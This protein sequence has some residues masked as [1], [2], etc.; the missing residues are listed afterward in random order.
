[1]SR[2]FMDKLTQ[3]EKL[4]FI[5]KLK[6]LCFERYYYKI[7]LQEYVRYSSGSGECGGDKFNDD[8]EEFI[9]LIQTGKAK[10][11]LITNETMYTDEEFKS[12]MDK[13]QDDLILKNKEIEELKSQIEKYTLNYCKCDDPDREAGYNYCYRCKKMVSDERMDEILK[14][15]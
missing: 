13:L 15:N 9:K 2:T 11:G 6:S 4:E 1:M 3:A 7:V 10:N 14:D 12:N 8:I 5:E